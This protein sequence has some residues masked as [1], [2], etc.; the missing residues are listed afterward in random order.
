MGKSYSLTAVDIERFCRDFVAQERQLEQL[1]LRILDSSLDI[2][3][4]FGEQEGKVVFL[5]GVNDKPL[6]TMEVD[7]EHERRLIAFRTHVPLPTPYCLDASP[8]APVE[9]SADL[10][11]ALNEVNY[12]L[13]TAYFTAATD[14]DQLTLHFFYAIPANDAPFSY[15]LLQ[16]IMLET[17]LWVVKIVPML[18][19]V[20]YGALCYD[21]FRT[22][23]HEHCVHLLEGSVEER[24]RW[25]IEHKGII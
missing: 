25:W 5:I 13:E 17:L 19:R 14:N 11:S 7:P 22:W 4:E 23:L 8:E 12:F 16:R 9:I 21:E 24:L 1:S 3:S 15:N 2:R 6:F 18:E 10:L 20:A